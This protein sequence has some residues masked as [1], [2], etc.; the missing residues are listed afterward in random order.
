MS[1]ALQRTF[2]LERQIC[3]LEEENERLNK[4]VEAMMDM[5]E[6]LHG[7]LVTIE[8]SLAVPSEQLGGGQ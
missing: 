7:K 5:I 4:T 2:D 1:E 8:A 3:S 6:T